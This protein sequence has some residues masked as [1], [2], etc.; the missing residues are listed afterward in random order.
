MKLRDNNYFIAGGL[1]PDNIKNL[2]IKYQP[3]GL[4]VSSGIE[5]SVGKKDFNLMK[6]FI[7]NVRIS[8]KNL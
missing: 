5:H 1:N 4:D 6:K 2:I 3:K 7:E 8:E